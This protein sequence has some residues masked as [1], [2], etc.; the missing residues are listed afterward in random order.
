ATNATT[1]ISAGSNPE[2]VAVNPVT[3]QI[4]VANE[5]SGNVT[6]I[7]GATTA[8]T[9]VSVGSGPLAIAVN[10]VTNEIY[11]ANFY[12]SNVTVID[13]AT[14]ATAMVSAGNNPQAV[15]VNPVTNRIYVANPGNGNNMTAIDGATNATTTV[16]AGDNPQAI[17]VNPVTNRIYVANNA[18][19][20]VTEINVDG[21][22]PVPL[23][24]TAAGV[25]DSL[26][27]NGTSIF[28]TVNATPAFTAT[29]TSDFTNF[30]AYSGLSAV[31]PSPANLFYWVDD[32]SMASWNAAAATGAPYQNPA[33]YTIMLPQQSLGV[34]TLYL[35]ADY[36]D[37]G[38]GISSSAGIGSSPVISNLQAVSYAVLPAPTTTTLTADVNPQNAGTA[39]MFTATVTPGIGRTALPTGSVY[40][41]DGS[42]L[43]GESALTPNGNAYTATYVWPAADGSHTIAALY[44]GDGNYASSTATLT[45]TVE[46][47]PT[48]I[49]IVAGNNQTSA[50][51]TAFTYSLEVL[52]TDA[53]NIPL[54]NVAVNFSG[55]GLSFNSGGVAVTDANGKASMAAMP[56]TSG[57]LNVT[58]SVAGLAATAIFTETGTGSS[59]V[60][61]AIAWPTPAAIAY[62][63]ALSG[64][65]LDATASYNSVSVPGTFTYSPA[66]GTV[67][68]VGAQ[69]LRVTFTPNDQTTY[70]TATATVT[71]QV[72]QATPT[73][74]WATPAAITYGAALSATQLNATASY[75]GTTV[76]GGFSYSPAAG[77]VLT[78]GTP[79]LTV[80]FTPSDTTDYAIATTT[81]SIAVNQATPS[82][83]WTPPAGIGYSTPL[84]S[85]QLN[86]TANVPG[87]F[88]YTPA[89]GTVLA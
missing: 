4:Y 32:G 7:D 71:L 56:S 36:G 29:V 21:S 74:T 20:N 61:P 63:T 84:T 70:T 45:E 67:P 2:A 27:V 5:N 59:Q 86:A 58:A 22:Q 28:T 9:T 82:L 18:S 46:G 12:S 37:E 48:A 30:P 77:T 39:V 65:Q 16:S 57:T 23:A 81:V 15:T 60:T 62:G 85:A 76:A 25:S 19:N 89:L 83:N 3:N 55:T 8:T 72:T 26:T 17:A 79:T 64:T 40:F 44:T 51:G 75:N 80:T 53:G 34:H 47:A 41:Y 68:G 42:T 14:T 24:V 43:L 31:N 6:V 78:A 69:T 1:T 87:Q 35:F 88:T 11:V 13:G 54:P 10:P 52:V 38:E 73:V 50:V 33:Q 66:S 49:N